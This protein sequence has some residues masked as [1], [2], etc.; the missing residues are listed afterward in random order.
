M[1]D[2]LTYLFNLFN[3]AF[4]SFFRSSHLGRKM[5]NVV[6]LIT[7]TGVLCRPQEYFSILVEGERTQARRCPRPSR[8]WWCEEENGSE[9]R[10]HSYRIGGRVL[11]HVPANVVIKLR[12]PPSVR[13]VTHALTMYGVM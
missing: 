7:F 9:S 10:T 12:K 1:Y 2:I 4:V 13:E 5:E 11:G 3:V 8:A 6:Y